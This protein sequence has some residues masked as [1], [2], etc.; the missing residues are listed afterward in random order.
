MEPVDFEASTPV[1]ADDFDLR[2]KALEMAI[3]APNID[4]PAEVV[5]AA[6]KFYAFLKGD[7]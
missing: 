5:A 4:T 6:E 1:R 2:A 7:A 3:D